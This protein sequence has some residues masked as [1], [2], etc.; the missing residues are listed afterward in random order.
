MTDERGRVAE[1]KQLEDIELAI[2]QRFELRHG[3]RNGR[4]GTEIGV[5]VSLARRDPMDRVD[6]F[7]IGGSFEYVAARRRRW[8]G[9]LSWGDSDARSAERNSW[10]S[11][12]RSTRITRRLHSGPAGRAFR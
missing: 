6:Q 12:T 10:W 5:H 2:R 4:P 8:P 7:G 3:V 9:V 11:S 1:G